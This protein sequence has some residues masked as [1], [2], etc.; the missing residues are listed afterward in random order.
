MMKFSFKYLLLGVLPSVLLV[1]GFENLTLQNGQESTLNFD[2]DLA[3]TLRP[4]KEL[5]EHI[6]RAVVDGRRT[7]RFDTFG[8]EAFWGGALAHYVRTLGGSAHP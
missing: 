2:K 4:D 8:D 5:A 3:S 6:V 7:F 1:A